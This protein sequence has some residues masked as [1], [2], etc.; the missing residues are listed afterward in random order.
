MKK[1]ISILVLALL[2]A[3]APLGSRA[4]DG[5]LFPYPV[6]PD[7]LMELQPRCDF[8]VSNFWKR[9]DFKSAFSARHKLEDCFADWVGF[10][11]YASADTVHAATDRLLANFKKSGPQMLAIARMAEKNLYSD[12]AQ[13]FSEEAYL[14]FAAAAAANKKIG[15][16]DRAHFAA[17]ERLIRHSAIGA[18]APALPIVLRDGS[19][20]AISPD[21]IAE[22]MIM[23]IGSDTDA[24]NMARAR[25][26]IDYNTN[27]LLRKGRLH[28]Y[29]VYTGSPSDEAWTNASQSYPDNWIVGAAADAAD[30]FDLRLNPEFYFLD[31]EGHVAA[32]RAPV[33]NILAAF[34]ALNMQN[35]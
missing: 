3:V 32:K 10:I 34:R 12:S 29:A 31:T 30:F 2:G 33:D 15:K 21:S 28:I 14:P 23:F 9:C 22:T 13:I 4:A 26:S 20:S 8:L 25:L 18:K 35:N 5:D 1:I 19:R 27:E 17:Q 11:P 16:E 24:A 6:P 7:D